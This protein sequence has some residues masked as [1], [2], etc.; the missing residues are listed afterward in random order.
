MACGEREKQEN[1]QVQG[2]IDEE[3]AQRT[4]VTAS[5]SLPQ[6]KHSAEVPRRECC[7]GECQTI[8]WTPT[9]PILAVQTFD[10]DTRIDHHLAVA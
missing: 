7:A 8:E 4:Q 3:E 9:P 6:R 10:S 5:T 1:A 2:K